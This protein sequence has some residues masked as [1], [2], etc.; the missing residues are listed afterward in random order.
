MGEKGQT[1]REEGAIPVSAA[2]MY[3]NAHSAFGQGAQATEGGAA[4]YVKHIKEEW[5]EKASGWLIFQSSCGLTKRENIFFP[6]VM[7]CM[8]LFY[9]R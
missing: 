2:A 7:V 6:P 8:D 3:P 4:K 1:G 9:I 5:G